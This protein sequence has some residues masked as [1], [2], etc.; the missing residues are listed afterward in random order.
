MLA[1]AEMKV[2]PRMVVSGEVACTVE[3]QAGFGRWRKVCR[4]THQPRH[5]LPYGVQYLGRSI[6]SSEALRI[7]RKL[8]YNFVPPG[9]SIT[10]LHL[11]DLQG[12]C[13]RSFPI[14]LKA[15]MPFITQLAPASAD[16]CLDM[17]VDEVRHQE[18]RIFR[19][20]I[21]SFGELD[22]FR[23]KRL[24]MC[25]TGVLLIWC[26]IPDMAVDDDQR[27][28]ARST[29]LEMLDRAIHFCKI[30]GV[31]YTLNIPTIGFEACGD[32]LGKR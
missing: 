28:P 7:Y 14:L 1:N 29:R 22:L 20:A 27:G 26:S 5:A 30:I 2:A 9:R 10:L 16:S 21:V 4:S 13:R 12:K 15:G 11:L 31:A 24:S 18:F 23:P 8:R 6:P 25:S 3:R 17:F 32:I 19:P